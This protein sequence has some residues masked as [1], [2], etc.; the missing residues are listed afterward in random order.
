MAKMQLMTM[1]RLALGK[2]DVIA[3]FLMQYGPQYS[4]RVV[5]GSVSCA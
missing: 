1:Q 5:N 4:G 3:Y 2:H